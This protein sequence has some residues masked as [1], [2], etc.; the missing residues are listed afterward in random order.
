[1]TPLALVTVAGMLPRK[2]Y[3]FRHLDLNYQELTNKD[4]EWADLIMLSGWGAQYRSILRVSLKCRN[5]KKK[6]LI[7]GPLASEYPDIL[8]N[9][10]HIFIGEAEGIDLESLLDDIANDNAPHL[11][12]VLKLP[13][14]AKNPSFTKV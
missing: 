13:D 7:G 9:I 10:D 8:R 4:I 12:K 14:I 6:I 1:M 5:L 11:I 2:K 3:K